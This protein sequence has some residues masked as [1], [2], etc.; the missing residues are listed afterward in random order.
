MRGARLAGAA[1]ERELDEAAIGARDSL[2]AGLP[3]TARMCALGRARREAEAEAEARDGDSDEAQDAWMPVYL[4]DEL[5]QP[6]IEG[7][8]D[9]YFRVRSTS[10]RA[11]AERF[12]SALSQASEDARALYDNPDNQAVNLPDEAEQRYR[13]D[14]DALR[15]RLQ[16]A[17]GGLRHLC[18][19]DPGDGHVR[20]LKREA[21]T[22]PPERRRR[23]LCDAPSSPTS[24]SATTTA[25]VPAPRRRWAP[26]CGAAAR[27]KRRARWRAAAAPR[28]AAERL[29]HRKR[30]R[31]RRPHVSA[32]LLATL[33]TRARPRCCSASTPPPPLLA[34]HGAAAAAAA[35]ARARARVIAARGEARR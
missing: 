26:W 4:C 19:A 35:A 24:G 21:Q 20:S 22:W 33:A 3:S 6:A 9:V 29:G 11:C 16:R 34:R 10:R 15:Q 7:F 17:G 2:G 32:A 12:R 28:A 23:R 30:R 8:A 25:A 31:P 18:R 5:A 27:R 13:M 1:L 14:L